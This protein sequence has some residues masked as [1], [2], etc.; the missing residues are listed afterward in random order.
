M[1]RG[2]DR[3]RSLLKILLTCGTS[4]AG[5]GQEDVILG[6]LGSGSLRCQA[7]IWKAMYTQAQQ[8]YIGL[9][10]LGELEVPECCGGAD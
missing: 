7:S 6:Y 5:R 2:I 4:H 1:M 8:C 9:C 10:G 3:L